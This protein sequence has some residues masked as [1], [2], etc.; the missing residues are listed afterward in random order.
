MSK[1]S[2]LSAMIWVALLVFSIDRRWL[3]AAFF[4]CVAAFFAGLGIIH[5]SE[6]FAGDFR[7][8]TGG[9]IKETSPFEFMMG[10]LSLA[11]VAVIYWVLQK[12]Q[13]KKLEEDDPDFD[14][15][16]GYLQP[17]VDNEMD[18]HFDHWFDALEPDNAV[19]TVTEKDPEG[20][21]DKLKDSS[22]D[23][24][25]KKDEK[26]EG[27]AW[28][29]PLRDYHMP[30][31][32]VVFSWLYFLKIRNILNV[33][34]WCPCRPDLMVTSVV[35]FQT[36]VSEKLCWSHILSIHVILK[37]LILI[38]LFWISYVVD[39]KTRFVRFW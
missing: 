1:G 32:F 9:N 31:V 13:G 30:W 26:S 23:D 37:Y 35:S 29:G 17:L 2:A 36:M 10:Y 14:K 11:G 27:E 6:S 8:G 18:D 12:Y 5:Q 33:S 19:T 34:R 4:C 15:D 25:L 38:G 16:H 24:D 28:G 39:G 20:E 3:T 21:G 7:D 22:E